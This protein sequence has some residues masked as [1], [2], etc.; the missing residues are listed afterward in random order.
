MYNYICEDCGASL[1]PGEICD[2]KRKP[3]ESKLRIVTYSDLEAAGDFNK[4][5]HPGDYVEDRIVDDMRDLFPPVK[6]ERGF[7]QAGEPYSHEFDPE[8][9]RW[10]STFPTFI[11]EG[12][13]WKYCGNCFIG[14]TTEPIK[15]E[16]RTEV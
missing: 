3:E 1:D 4:A 12:K 2:C 13:N 15:T 6:M 14:K 7:L 5:A 16:R 9:G 8:A 11:K 10:R